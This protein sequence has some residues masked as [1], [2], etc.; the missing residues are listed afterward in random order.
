MLTRSTFGEGLGVKGS[1]S[2]AWQEMRKPSRSP[3]RE[4]FT[5]GF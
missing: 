2:R 5:A 3:V 4:R 1:S